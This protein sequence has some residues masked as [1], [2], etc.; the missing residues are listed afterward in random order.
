LIRFFYISMLI[1]SGLL[2][3]G[4]TTS[5][6][7]EGTI[8]TP[9]VAKIPVNVGVYYSDDFKS[10]QHEET[11]RQH[12]NFKVD[13]G[14]QNLLFFRNL[15]TAVFEN[16]TEI[17]ERPLADEQSSVAEEN[18][19]GLDGIL[20]PEIIKYGFLT[21]NVSGL[22]FYSA[23]IHYRM[24]LYDLNNAKLGEWIIVGYGKSER[25]LFGTTDSLSEATM[26][27]IRD[28]GARIAIEMES[29]P[30]IQSWLEDIGNQ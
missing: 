26:L 1:V 11:I 8:P 6:T 24:S 12:G 17:D 19:A 23:S 16:V 5:V 4:C 10:F 3:V 2:I 20:I 25:T 21:P 29:Q 15:M 30:V 9:L 28:G 27:A 14:G 22:K 18:A 7:V 13:M